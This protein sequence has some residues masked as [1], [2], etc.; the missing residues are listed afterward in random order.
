[1][2]RGRFTLLGRGGGKVAIVWE[3]GGG[4]C[5]MR[6]WGATVFDRPKAWGN[7]GGDGR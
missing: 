1:M 4:E 5:F 2:G 3:G 7:G 6:V